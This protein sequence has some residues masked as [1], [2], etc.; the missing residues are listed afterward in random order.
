M[1]PFIQYG[2]LENGGNPNY[3]SQFAT[4][5]R[6]FVMDFLDANGANAAAPV[7]LNQ[8]FKAEEVV[9]A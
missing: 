8:A 2:G 5:P 3:P 4:F 7:R 9:T 1:N 6:S